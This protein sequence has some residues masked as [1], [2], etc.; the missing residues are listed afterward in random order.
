LDR[1]REWCGTL[2]EDSTILGLDEH[3]GI[4]FDFASGECLVSGVSSVSVVR[5]CDPEIFATGS[6]FPFGELGKLVSLEARESGIPSKVWEMA[7]AAAESEREEVPEE[8][9]AL[10]DA[11]TKAREGK[12]WAESDRLRD[13]IAALGWGVQDTPEGAK[14]EKI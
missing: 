1:F 4:T 3:T 12:D 14:L 8:V 11:R 13:E 6:V 2:P 9:M 7:A 10:M 5:E